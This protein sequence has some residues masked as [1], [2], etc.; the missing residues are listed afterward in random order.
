VKTTEDVAASLFGI[1]KEPSET[2]KAFL[3]RLAKR[4]D[5]SLPREMHFENDRSP[6]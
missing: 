5:I 1:E 3:Q 2:G 6:G 4:F